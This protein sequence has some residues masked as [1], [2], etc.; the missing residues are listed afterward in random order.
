MTI[1]TKLPQH[2]FPST[3]TAS[4]PSLQPAMHEPLTN[5]PCQPHRSH[6]GH[7]HQ[8]RC[9]LHDP[10]ISLKIA[11]DVSLRHASTA[12]V[13]L[14]AHFVSVSASVLL[15]QLLLPLLLVVSRGGG[16]GGG[17]QAALRHA[18]QA[19]VALLGGGRQ[20]LVQLLGHL[21]RLAL[22]DAAGGWGWTHTA[23]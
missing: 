7:G 9:W 15:P 19:L 14:S 10:S 18:L 12:P 6:T 16:G 20:L 11:T 5:R 4:K 2:N 22:Q 1:E 13:F 3:H 8:P 17:G 23:R 21:G